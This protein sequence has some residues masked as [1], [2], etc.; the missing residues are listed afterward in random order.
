VALFR[1][2]DGVLLA[3]DA[4]TTVKQE[5]F[6]AVLTQ[7]PEIHGPPMYY[8]QDWRAAASSVRTLAA[9]QPSIA[10]TGHG[11]P[12]QGPEMLEGL[13]ILA[14]HFDDLAVPARGRYVPR[15]AIADENG[16]VFVPPPVRDWRAAALVALGVGAVAGAVAL[17]LAGRGRQ[18]G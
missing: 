1:E 17:R 3:G 18:R 4:F 9:L 11:V 14:R 6:F 10:A 12:L 13:R 16:V 2:R 15:P 7:R 8:T 5:S